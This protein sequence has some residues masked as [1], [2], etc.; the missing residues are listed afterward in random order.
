MYRI[1]LL[2]L[3]LVATP[4]TF[5]S[6]KKTTALQV[7]TLM[8]RIAVFGAMT[9]CALYFAITRDFGPHGDSESA[10]VLD[11]DDAGGAEHRDAGAGAVDTRIVGGTN[12]LRLYKAFGRELRDTVSNSSSIAPNSSAS[13]VP[14]PDP[15]PGNRFHPSH[16]NP[17][18]DPAEP[19]VRLWRMAG[20][21]LLFGGAVYAMIAQ[22]YVP[23][24]FAGLEA[25]VPTAGEH[26]APARGASVA[27]TQSSAPDG[28]DAAEPENKPDR[29]YA[30]GI[31]IKVIGCVLA[32]YLVVCWSAVWAYHGLVQPEEGC[33]AHTTH[34]CGLQD[35]YMFGFG[36][37]RPWELSRFILL[38]PLLSMLSSFP[39]IAITLRDSLILLYLRTCG[40]SIA[41]NASEGVVPS[42]RNAGSGGDGSATSA[43]RITASQLGTGDPQGS[44]EDNAGNAI[45]PSPSAGIEMQRIDGG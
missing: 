18:G 5:Y 24:L 37:V 28:T 4:L 6:L 7:G 36:Y 1:T 3:A 26:G 45:G 44:N 17:D 15:A 21:P 13:I 11:P 27:P 2:L 32:L 41:S 20:L 43:S 9:A 33:D 30:R 23:S 22:Q 25:A 39:L 42:I 14:D 10:A 16:L 31:V 35:L 34:A 38:A 40:G 8:T 29:W 12:P 19:R